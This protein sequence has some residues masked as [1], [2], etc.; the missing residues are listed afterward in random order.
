MSQHQ[1][2]PHHSETSR[3]PPELLIESIY[4][5]ALAV[6]SDTNI[7]LL[8][9][10]HERFGSYEKAWKRAT[11]QL[12]TTLSPDT[13]IVERKEKTDPKKEW[14]KLEKSE[15]CLVLATHPD[16]PNLLK[17]IPSPP[18]GLYIQGDLISNIS[19]APITQI[20]SEFVP[21][22][23]VGTR[24]PTPYGILQTKKIIQALAGTRTLIISGLAH[25]VDSIAHETALSENLPTW[26]VI[27]HGHSMFSSE[28]ISLVKRILASSHGCIISEYAPDT[29]AI[30][31]H[32]PQ[33]NR[34]IA[35]LT[36]HTL[37]TQ[38]PARSGALI[39]AKAAFD[40]NREVYALTADIDNED[41]AG[42]LTI[43]E[44]FTAHPITSYAQLPQILHGITKTKQRS[45]FT[46][47]PNFITRDP[48]L[49]SILDT[50]TY[51]YATPVSQLFESCG[52][53]N[54][55]LLFQKLTELEIEDLIEQIPG[56]YRLKK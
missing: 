36:N 43:I 17:Q 15:I 37:V 47:P 38:A 46:P 55:G 6:C 11:S 23:V 56:G 16:Y 34:I 18:L 32:F 10:L 25:G 26:A 3:L 42:N 39:T 1:H 33:R 19:A 9:K 20:L 31:Y 53:P 41:C 12:L 27:G 4:Y 40:T 50:L 8:K 2:N 44:D 48:Y 51:K 49:K 13:D 7:S 14:E 22:S 21:L 28:R 29:P 5:H 35:G 30:S 45:L 54:I 52:I 24:R